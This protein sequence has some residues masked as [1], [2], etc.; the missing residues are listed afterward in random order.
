MA[1][2]TKAEFEATA[3]KWVDFLSTKGNARGIYRFMYCVFPNA[4]AA[5]RTHGLISASFI[6]V[7]NKGKELIIWPRQARIPEAE[8][9]IRTSGGEIRYPKEY[10]FGGADPTPSPSARSNRNRRRHGPK[11]AVP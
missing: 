6:G 9:I 8:S 7:E 10:D 11:K 4:S 2:M 5:K 1:I 3:D